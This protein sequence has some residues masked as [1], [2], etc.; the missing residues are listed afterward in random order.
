MTWFIGTAFQLNSLLDEVT[1]LVEWPVVISGAFDEKYLKL[2]NEVLIATMQGH[3][4]YF[5]VVDKENNLL[6]F[7]YQ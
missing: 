3:Q 2:P 7:Q 1:A 6:P 4:K 5:P